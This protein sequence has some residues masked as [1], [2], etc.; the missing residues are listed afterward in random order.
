MLSAHQQLKLGA[1][2]SYLAIA[3]N[4]GSALIFSPWMLSKIGSGDYGLYALASSLINMFLLDFGISS[5][6][7]RFV[8][9]Y[10]SENNQQKVNE[11][12]A[13]V[14]KLFFGIVTIVSILLVGIY[15][16][17]DDIY[18]SLT[19]E[20]L[21]RFKVVYIIT[22]SYS[23]LSFPLSATLNGVLNSYEKFVQ[24][25]LCDVGNKL[26]SIALIVAALLLDYGLYAMVAIHAV[27]N[28][29]MYAVKLVFLKLNTPVKISWF[30]W[31]RDLLKEIFAFSAWILINSICSRL[32]MNIMPNILAATVGT[33]AITIFS[34]SAAIEGCSYTLASA[35]DG[36]FLPR[37]ARIT[38]GEAD[39]SKILPLMIKVG[40]FQYFVLGL[41]V[42]G[43]AG[44]GEEFVLLWLG[45]DYSLVYPCA[46]LLLLSAPFYLSQMI[47][48]NTMVVLGLVKYLT[49]INLIKAV[50][51]VLLAIVLSLYWGVIGACVS[52][53]IAY[54]VRNL[55]NMYVYHR[56]LRLN[57]I[58]FCKA[59]YIRMSIPMFL[60]LL[61][62]VGV[63]QLYTA[64][65][66]LLLTSKMGLLTVFYIL[67]MWILAFNQEEKSRY[68][69]ILKI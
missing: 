15:F 39:M 50:L 41:I 28:M 23:V 4:I 3:I 20:E 56:H 25:K 14:Y 61:A 37:I 5:A 60:T 54:N 8:S 21:E 51:N 29:L 55:A 33:L 2:L 57:V 67:L 19:P 18:Q 69:N 26:L 12:L 32:M 65:S 53:C 46:L 63:N 13:V 40:R 44:V 17:V 48:K 36:M 66:W 42:V 38:Y 10:I 59:C 16:F 34:F 24:M 68:K 52:I 58:R 1:L 45:Q 6:V 22:A 9:K 47:A 7:S 35:L 31:N 11:L 64:D 27:V 49:Y 30:Y 43:F 62:A